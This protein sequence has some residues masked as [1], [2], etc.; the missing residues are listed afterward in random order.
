MVAWCRQ[1]C[2]AVETEPIPTAAQ[3]ALIPSPR[4]S[5]AQAGDPRPDA[6]REN[7]K[8][9]GSRTAF[10]LDGSDVLVRKTAT[11]TPLQPDH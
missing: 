5:D 9:T 4:I 7:S 6:A 11:G 1:Q 10:R 3:E 2:T 8:C